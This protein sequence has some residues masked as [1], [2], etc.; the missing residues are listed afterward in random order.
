MMLVKTKNQTNNDNDD[1]TLSIKLQSRILLFLTQY[2]PCLLNPSCIITSDTLIFLRFWVLQKRYAE[3]S[4]HNNPTRY[5]PERSHQL[6]N[7]KYLSID[8]IQFILS[9]MHLQRQHGWD[10]KSVTNILQKM[11]VKLDPYSNSSFERFYL[12]TYKATEIP[13]FIIAC[14]FLLLV[15][16]ISQ[17]LNTVVNHNDP[18]LPNNMTQ[19]FQP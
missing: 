3:L 19:G 6:I 18:L 16:A 10:E 4:M 15:T 11:R 13:P 14:G 12:N 17:G 2:I 1:L 9:L 5:F 7:A 8:V